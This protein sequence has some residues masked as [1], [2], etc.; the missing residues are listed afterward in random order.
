MI[1]RG[2]WREQAVSVIGRLRLVLVSV[3]TIGA[4]AALGSAWIFANAAADQAFD[5]C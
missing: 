2:A 1:C 5:G 3:F 4:V